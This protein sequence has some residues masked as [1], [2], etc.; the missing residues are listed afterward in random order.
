VQTASWGRWGWVAAVAAGSVWLLVWAHQAAAH[1]TTSVNEKEVVLGLTWM[2]SGKLLVVPFV[3]LGAAIA[4]LHARR[5]RP[6]RLGRLGFAV[7]NGALAALF[8]GA[9]LEFWSFPWGSYTRD[10]DE[11]IPTF[12][13]VVQTLASVALAAGMALLSVDLGRS[14]VLPVWM[15]L[16]LFLGAATTIYLTPVFPVPGLAWVVLGTFLWLTG[17]SGRSASP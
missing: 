14:G 7:S 8:V 1:G 13:G 11:P 3:V 5:G 4:A 12:G 17:R 15:G 10:F 6:G 2:D 9:A 16:V